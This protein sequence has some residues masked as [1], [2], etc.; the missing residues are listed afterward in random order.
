MIIVKQGG[1]FPIKNFD[2]KIYNADGDLLGVDIDYTYTAPASYSGTILDRFKLETSTHTILKGSVVNIKG[3]DDI[4]N[5]YMVMGVGATTI[6]VEPLMSLSVGSTATIT[7]EEGSITLLSALEEGQYNLSTNEII[8]VADT[9]ANLYINKAKIR[10]RY[11]NLDDDIDIDL[12][13]NEAKES[14]IADFSFDPYFYKTL[15]LGQLTELQKRK[16]QVILTSES[17]STKAIDDY[18]ALL[19]STIN[20]LNTRVDNKASG[21][22]TKDDLSK[23]DKFVIG[24]GS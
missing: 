6:E 16:I 10:T 18:K 15:D 20:Y 23:N 19:K 24:W 2:N 3:E 14:V 8:I 21:D 22:V 5:D 1:S 9:F 17:D 12:L 11:K 7:Q 4:T 13:N